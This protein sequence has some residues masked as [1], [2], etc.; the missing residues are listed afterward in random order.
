MGQRLHGI[1]GQWPCDLRQ[2]EQL[3]PLPEPAR[4]APFLVAR[5]RVQRDGFVAY[6]G[7][8]TACPETWPAARWKSDPSEAYLEFSYRGQVVASH[9][10]VTGPAT[11]PLAGQWA[12]LTKTAPRRPKGPMAY[13]VAAPAVQVRPLEEYDALVGEWPV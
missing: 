3:Q 11:V 10:R 12:G 13:Q 8:A 6:E 2:E 5:R 7:V 1:T 9:R 4:L